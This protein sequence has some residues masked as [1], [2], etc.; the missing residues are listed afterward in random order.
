MLA[1]TDSALSVSS[2]AGVQA[3]AGAGGKI[4]AEIQT[5]RI[6]S[7]NIDPKRVVVTAIGSNRSK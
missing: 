6:I 4:V 3:V 1:C 5:D 2:V 7:P